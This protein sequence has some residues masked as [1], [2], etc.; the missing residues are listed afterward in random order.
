MRVMASH[1]VCPTVLTPDHGVY[2]HPVMVGR[3]LNLSTLNMP[4]EVRSNVT[5][6]PLFCLLYILTS[7]HN[8]IYF[9][10]ISGFHYGCQLEY[11]N[12][13]VQLSSTYHNETLITCGVSE[14]QVGSMRS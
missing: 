13:T 10:Q 6:Q 12:N 4:P 8:C 1:E 9:F 3:D 5:C 14:N 2:T 11:G 7:A